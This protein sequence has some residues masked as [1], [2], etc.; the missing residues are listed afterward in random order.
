MEEW[1]P[2]PNWENYLVS[3]LGRIFSIRAGKV[4]K[5][6]ISSFGYEVVNIKKHGRSYKVSVSRHMLSAFAPVKGWERLEV[7]HNDGVKTNNVLSNL[8]WATEKENAADRKIHGTEM[9]A[10]KNPASKISA[11]AARIIK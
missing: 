2:I 6:H 1:K 8:R 3:S 7:A 4:M 10:E 9:Y 11:L 5:S